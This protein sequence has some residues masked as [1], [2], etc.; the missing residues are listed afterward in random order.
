MLLQYPFNHKSLNLNKA[1]PIRQQVYSKQAVNNKSALR[2]RPIFYK[3]P[4]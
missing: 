3:G 2:A 1:L 4:S